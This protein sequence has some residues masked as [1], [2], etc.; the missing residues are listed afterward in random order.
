MCHSH[1]CQI[2]C[3]AFAWQIVLGPEANLPTRCTRCC[4]QCSGQRVHH[5]SPLFFQKTQILHNQD[6]PL[7]CCCLL[8]H[9][10][11]R[12]K[13]Y[14]LLAVWCQSGAVPCWCECSL[15]QQQID[16]YMYL[17]ILHYSEVTKKINIHSSLMGKNAILMSE[18][19]T[20]PM[21]R[22]VA[23]IINR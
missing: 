7:S 11:S 19:Y 1:W 17:K 23:E 13:L 5:I 14:S 6:G 9:C 21:Y 4:S 2:Q 8:F 18:K 10:L 15:N 16:R 12:L 3:V 22:K 20:N